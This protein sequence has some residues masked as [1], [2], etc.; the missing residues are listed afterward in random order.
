M[1]NCTLVWWITIFGS[2]HCVFV[3]HREGELMVF[4][5]VVPTVT[6]G[7]ERV[8]VQ[9][10]LRWLHHWWIY[11][12]FKVHFPSHPIWVSF[13]FPQSIEIKHNSRLCEDFLV[14]KGSDAVQIQS[15]LRWFGMSW[16]VELRKVRQK[17]LSASGDFSRTTGKPLEDHRGK[18]HEA[19]WLNFWLPR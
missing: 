10:V 12:K 1:D 17:V 13:V 11:W 7:E 2:N 15:Q 6:H 18:P 4:T 9:G 14:K 16:D 3:R 19:D 5:Y 8:M